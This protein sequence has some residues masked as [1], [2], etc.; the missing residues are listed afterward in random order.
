MSF[1]DDHLKRLKEQADDIKKPWL[2]H[3]KTKAGEGRQFDIKAILA[4][5]EAAENIVFIPEIKHRFPIA[6]KAW[7]KSKGE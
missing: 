6:Y 3:F 2:I 4:R 7:R 5:L 1:S